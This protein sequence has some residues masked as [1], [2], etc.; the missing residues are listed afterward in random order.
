MKYPLVFLYPG[1]G[2]QYVGMGKD[3]YQSYPG[4]KKLFDHADQLLGFSLSD[5]C[6]NGAE[7][8]LNKDLNAQL[9]VYTVSC[10]ITDILRSKGIAPHAVSGYS[11]GFYAAAYSAGCFDFEQGLKIVRNAGQILLDEGRKHEGAMAVI[12]GLSAEDVEKF[13]R[14]IGNVHV[15]IFNTHRQIIIS[16]LSTS[17]QKVMERSLSADALDAYLLNVATAYHS[18]WVSNSEPQLLEVIK[19]TPLQDPNIPIVSYTTLQQ[20]K[21]GDEVKKIMAMQLPRQVRWVE[22]IQFFRNNGMKLCV[23]MG[24][25]AVL[26]RTVRWIDRTIEMMV[27]DKAKK[28]N[29]V[30]STCKIE[31]NQ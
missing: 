14:E 28:L 13:C 25:G 31:G 30:I 8:E 12:F 26:S 4:A 20:L 9:A 7:D 19:E 15:A 2:S 29:R 18:E 17:I 21:S 1:Q 22:L 27:T 16:G 23:E 11:A 6:F 24:P 10:I 5:L 3:L